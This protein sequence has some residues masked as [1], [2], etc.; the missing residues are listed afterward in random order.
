MPLLKRQNGL[1]VQRG[2]KKVAEKG[3]IT[4]IHCMQNTELKKTNKEKQQTNKETTIRICRTKDVLEQLNIY[5]Q[6]L[7]QGKVHEFI[8][9]RVIPFAFCKRHFSEIGNAQ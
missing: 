6:F 4:Y 7:L 9:L 5:R 1:T 2:T 3:R 8:L